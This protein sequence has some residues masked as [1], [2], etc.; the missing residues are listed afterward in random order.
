MFTEGVIMRPELSQHTGP[1]C[2]PV[3]SLL[4]CLYF[5]AQTGL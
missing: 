3:S 5:C 1:H 2:C 4:L